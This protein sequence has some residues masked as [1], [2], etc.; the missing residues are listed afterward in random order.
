[1]KTQPW[2]YH[3]CLQYNKVPG[4]VA[5]P[6]T[7]W[8]RFLGGLQFRY[9][10]GQIQSSFASAR[11]LH[12]VPSGHTQC[13]TGAKSSDCDIYTNE[14][15]QIYNNETHAEQ[16]A[17]LTNLLNKTVEQTPPFHVVCQMHFRSKH[18]F[19]VRKCDED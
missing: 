15:T 10:A 16:T 13:P 4:N 18:H 17:S 14:V 2:S 19:T 8:Q 3:P 5:T 11:L 1:M 6:P 7:K 12:Q 9:C